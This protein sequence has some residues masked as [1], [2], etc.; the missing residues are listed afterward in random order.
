MNVQ[1]NITIFAGDTQSLGQADRARADQAQQASQGKNKT[2]YAGNFLTESPLR[3]RLQQRKAQ[4]QERAMKIVGDTWNGDRKIDEQLQESRNRLRDLR[5]SYK[6][7]QDGLKSLEAKSDEWMAYYEVD[8]DGQE[9]Q[10]LELLKKE[11][12]S[13]HYWTGIELTR[14][15]EA[16]LAEIKDR[17]L[18]EYQEIQLEVNE[19]AWVHRDTIYYSGRQIEKENAV[20]RGIRLERLKKDPMLKAQKEAEQVMEAAR[21]EAIGMIVDEAKDHLDE[22]QEKKEEEAEAIEEKKEAQEELLEKRKDREDEMEEL[23]KE[24]PLEEMADLKNVQSEV[25]QEIQNLVSKMNLVAEDI[26]G[27]KVDANI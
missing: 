23:M 11:Q 12:A 15:E 5:A 7:A 9:Q 25:Q 21:D 18:T 8:P 16:K 2:I 24:M 10:D 19:A 27:A 13:Q 17:G 20:I 22:E 6:D 1:N 26:K 4:A 14:E 3:D